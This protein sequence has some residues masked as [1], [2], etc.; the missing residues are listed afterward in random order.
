M[1]YELGGTQR[2]GDTEKMEHCTLLSLYLLCT[3]VRWLDLAGQLNKRV[4]LS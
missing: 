2:Y 3:S 4:L 1:S